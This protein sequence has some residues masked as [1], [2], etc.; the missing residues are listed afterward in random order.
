M[1]VEICFPEVHDQYGCAHLDSRHTEG[2]GLLNESASC[3]DTLKVVSK[4]GENGKP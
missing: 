1:Q 3:T 2:R 4:A